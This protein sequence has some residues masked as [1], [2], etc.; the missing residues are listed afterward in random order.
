M[1]KNKTSKIDSEKIL[2]LDNQ[3]CFKLYAAS[4]AMTQAYAPLLA[5]LDLTYPQYLTMMVLWE[6]DE[7]A[8]KDL[9]E[10]LSLDS[11]TLSPL[12]KKLEA[13]KFLNK[14]RSDTDERVVTIKLTQKG[15]DLKKKALLIPPQIACQ[16]ELQEKEFFDL[17]KRLAHLIKNLTKPEDVN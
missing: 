8:V 10:R 5:P 15:I 14:T 9:G 11:G 1:S 12:I 17:Q 2:H 7:I 3:L 6:N 16:V 4:K 13:K